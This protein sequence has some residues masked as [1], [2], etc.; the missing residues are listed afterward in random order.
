MGKVLEIGIT[1]IKGGQIQNVSEIEV[2]KG[3]G[4]IND[5]KFKENNQKTMQKLFF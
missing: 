3:K 1:N 4:I 5:R 2:L